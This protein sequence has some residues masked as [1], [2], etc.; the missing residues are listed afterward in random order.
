[1]KRKPKSPLLKAAASKPAWRRWNTLMERLDRVRL[2]R[3][4][5]KTAQQLEKLGVL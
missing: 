2:Q 3:Q 4:N 5:R 1:M